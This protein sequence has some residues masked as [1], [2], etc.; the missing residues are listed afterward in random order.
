MKIRNL[1]LISLMISAMVFA[2]CEKIEMQTEAVPTTQKPELPMLKVQ[3]GMPVFESEEQFDETIDAV[4]HSTYQ[5]LDEWEKKLGYTSYR[6]KLNFFNIEMEKYGKDITEET[7][8][9]LLQEYSDVVVLKTDKDG[10][11][12][13]QPIINDK[14]NETIFN[15]V[16][17]YSTNDQLYYTDSNALYSIDKTL[18]NMVSDISRFGKVEYQRNSAEKGM[19]PT[20]PVVDFE[21]DESGCRNDS[22]VKIEIEAIAY[23]YGSSQRYDVNVVVRGYD[24]RVCVWYNYKTTLQFRDVEGVVDYG[25]NGSKTFSIADDDTGGVEQHKLEGQHRLVDGT[26]QGYFGFIS[27]H[28]RGKS[29]GTGLGWAEINWN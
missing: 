11:S 15:N 16:R 1:F 21:Y 10:E 12:Y 27:A 3:D 24:R 26:Y 25:Y 2:G 19:H 29:R 17:M 22:K 6:T 8:N 20:K 28:G 18:K 7:L 9:I 23:V 14:I 4:S 13:I 5:Q